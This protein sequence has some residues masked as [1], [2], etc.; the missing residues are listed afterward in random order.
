MSVI[1][2][3]NKNRIW[4]KSDWFLSDVTDAI[5]FYVEDCCFLWSRW[6]CL[7]AKVPYNQELHGIIKD[8]NGYQKNP[9]YYDLK[10]G[11]YKTLS[12]ASMAMESLMI[13]K[14]I[15]EI[16]PLDGSTKRDK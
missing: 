3:D 13:V 6:F 8:S 14:G 12:S 7:Y 9:K 10:I 16:N 1:G 2:R 4:F 5:K 15:E 11:W